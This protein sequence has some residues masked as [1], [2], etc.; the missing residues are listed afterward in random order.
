V[1]AFV[2]LLIK[3]GGLALQPMIERR[4]VALTPVVGVLVALTAIGFEAM[5]DKDVSF[6]LFSGQ[7]QLPGLVHEA[8]SWSAGAL[9]ALVLCKSVAYALSLSCFRGGPVFPGMFIGAALGILASQL[10]GLSM[11]AGVG[12]GVGAMSVAMLGLPMVSVLLP[13]LLLIND[14]I[15]LTPLIIVGVVTSY[16]VSARLAP[17]AAAAS[18]PKPT[19]R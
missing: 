19:R 13:S 14:A 5:T 18:E 16:V 3:R 7:A 8:S 1:A 4:Q 15:S 12:I 10:P 17:A 2:G 9:I 11:V 6:V